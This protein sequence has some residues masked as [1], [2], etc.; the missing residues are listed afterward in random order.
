MRQPHNGPAMFRADR[1][2]VRTS[3]NSTSISASFTLQLHVGGTRDINLVLQDS[4]MRITESGVRVPTQRRADLDI[5][6][7][8]GR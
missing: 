8:Y 7:A 2:Q 5:P 4:E 3:A 6:P 1:A